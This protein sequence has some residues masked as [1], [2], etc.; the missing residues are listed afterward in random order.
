MSTRQQSGAHFVYICLQN[1]HPVKKRTYTKA[2]DF[3][4]K[5]LQFMTKVTIFAPSWRISISY[6]SPLAFYFIHRKKLSTYRTSEYNN[7][8]QRSFFTL[9]NTLDNTNRYTLSNACL[10][11][12]ASVKTGSLHNPLIL[13][14]KNY[15]SDPS[16]IMIWSCAPAHDP[17]NHKP[18]IYG[19]K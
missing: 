12:D 17:K 16:L 3:S 2:L 1:Y 15:A 10:H 13:R 8:F 6:V 19:Q 18:R 9:D 7:C 11:M 5:N 14:W 4:Q